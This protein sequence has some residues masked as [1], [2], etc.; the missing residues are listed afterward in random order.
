[1]RFAGQVV[2]ITGASQG[3]G[4]SLAR[5]FAKEGARLVLTARSRED[6]EQVA[7]SCTPAQVAVLPADLSDLDALDALSARAIQA[8][9]QVDVLVNNAG[10]SQR[11]RAVHTDLSVLQRLMD[12]NFFAPIALTRAVLPAM[13][14]RG[15]GQIAVTSSVAGHVGTP[16]RSGYCASKHAIQGWFDSLRAELHGTGVGVTILSPGY[17]RTDISLRAL[18][19]DGSPH[20]KLGAGNAKGIHPDRCAARMVD[21]I[22]AGR[23]EVFIGGWEIAAVYLKRWLPG[24]VARLIHRA[25]PRDD[26]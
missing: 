10:I 8:F 11:G 16:L 15:R 3:I 25:A 19:E 9:G 26:A 21:A 4:A 7:L 5:A 20:G 23:R 17:I 24:L 22:A 1:M 18:A 14:E 6:L 13:L 12:L 2:W